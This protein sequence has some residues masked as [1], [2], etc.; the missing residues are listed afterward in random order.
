[1]RTALMAL[2]RAYQLALSPYIGAQCRFQPTCS[3]Y[4]LEALRVHG[5]AAGLRLGLGRLLRCHPFCPG[6]VDPVPSE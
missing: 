4:T 6:G 1:M 5:A 3:E 2:I